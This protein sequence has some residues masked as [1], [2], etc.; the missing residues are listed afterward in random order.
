MPPPCSTV[1][2]DLPLVAKMFFPFE[3]LPDETLLGIFECLEF[4][5]LGRC[6]QVSK[7]FRKIALDETLWQTIKTVDEDVSVEFLVQAL[8]H[9]TKHLSFESTSLSLQ[10]EIPI[11]NLLSL[12]GINDELPN[13]NFYMQADFLIDIMNNFPVKGEISKEDY[14]ENYFPEKKFSGGGRTKVIGDLQIQRA[15][16][17]HWA[18]RSVIETQRDDLINRSLSINPELKKEISKDEYILRHG[19]KSRVDHEKSF[20]S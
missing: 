12:Y 13:P 15:I 20:Y 3:N 6:L 5:D 10:T 1:L 9:G 16:F 18:R 11:R 4:K 2:P 7:M 19:I 17:F 14:R 8:T